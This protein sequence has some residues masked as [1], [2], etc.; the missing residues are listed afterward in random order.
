[1]VS[2]DVTFVLDQLESGLKP[3][4]S[5]TA[6][7]VVAQAEGVNVPTSAISDG[8]VTVVHG[9]KQERRAVTTGLAGNSSTIVLSGLKAGEQVSLP[10]ASTSGTSSLLS[11]LAGRAAR[12]RWAAARW[13]AAAASPVGASP[14]A[15]RAPAAAARR[16]REGDVTRESRRSLRRTARSRPLVT[17]DTLAANIPARGRRRA[18][19]ISPAGREQDV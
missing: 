1:M 7:V 6:E 11:R 8:S 14:A 19:V 4:M 15:A 16:G 2:Y 3:G 17:R 5:A 10:L 18:S 12:V 9:G 13:A